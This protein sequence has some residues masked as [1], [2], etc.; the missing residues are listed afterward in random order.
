MGYEL[1][2]CQPCS[3]CDEHA[4]GENDW[5]ECCNN[6]PGELGG[7]RATISGTTNFPPGSCEGGGPECEN[8]PNTDGTYDINDSFSG[9][10][11]ECHWTSVEYIKTICGSDKIRFHLYNE[12]VFELGFCYRLVTLIMDIHDPVLGWIVGFSTWSKVIYIPAHD[13]N[14]YDLDL[15]DPPGYSEK[16]TCDWPLTV[17]I[18]KI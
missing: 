8:C 14:D 7:Y 3:D 13:C 5:A 18:E 12:P 2:D 1:Q 4:C 16:C 9:T 10:P 17:H 11:T 15:D 6:D